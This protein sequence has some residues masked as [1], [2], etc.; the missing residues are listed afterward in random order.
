MRECGEE[1]CEHFDN[2]P[3]L[4]VD[5]IATTFHTI[6]TRRR[7]F[8]SQR[9]LWHFKILIGFAVAFSELFGEPGGFDRISV[10]QI[11]M[12]RAGILH[13]VIYHSH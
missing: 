1:Q 3:N 9:I 12:I 7:L 4:I 8:L 2:L 10:Q 11:V 5:N 13:Y 6:D